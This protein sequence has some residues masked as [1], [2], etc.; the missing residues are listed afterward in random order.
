MQELKS[1]GL[2]ESQPGKGVYVRRKPGAP[3][4]SPDYVALVDQ[5]DAMRENFSAV[6]DSIRDRLASIENALALRK[7]AGDD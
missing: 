4:P 6:I 3:Q 5:I 7:D 2:I 1:E